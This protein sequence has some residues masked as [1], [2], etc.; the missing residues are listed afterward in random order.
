MPACRR[1]T[2]PK[3]GLNLPDRSRFESTECDHLGCSSPRSRISTRQP[4]LV[5]GP[6]DIAAVRRR[7]DLNYHPFIIAKIERLRALNN[8][9]EILT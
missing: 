5:E 3:K 6:A 4:V 8:F 1:R 7:A 2:P 9:D